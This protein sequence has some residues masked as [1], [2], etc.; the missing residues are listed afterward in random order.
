MFVMQKITTAFRGAA[1]EN[2]EK[3]VDANAIRIF[4]QEIYDCEGSMHQAKHDLARVIAERMRLQRVHDQRLEAVKLRETQA[5][6]ALD[7]QETALAQEIA[8]WLAEQEK[9]AQEEQ[10][11]LKRLTDHE[12]KLRATLRAAAK[13][14]QHYRRELRLVQATQSSQQATRALAC[15]ANSLGAR[16]VD[17]QESLERIQAKQ[18]QFDDMQEALMTVGD[19]LGQQQLDAKLKQAGITTDHAADSILARLRRQHAENAGSSGAP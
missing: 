13:H 8:V 15:K 19:D 11:A 1:R 16:I 2:A 5:L 14:I 4:E 17:M 7:K 3:I 9:A 10:A 6:Q 18:E 12:E